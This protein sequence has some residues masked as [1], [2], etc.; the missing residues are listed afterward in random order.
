MD[1]ELKVIEFFKQ[2]TDG[3]TDCCINYKPHECGCLVE[4]IPFMGAVEKFIG[5]YKELCG[6]WQAFGIDDAEKVFN[7]TCG[8]WKKHIVVYNRRNK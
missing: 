5:D 1:L 3:Q 4:S 7:A 8:I 6:F 2:F